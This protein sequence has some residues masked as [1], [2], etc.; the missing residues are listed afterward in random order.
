MRDDTSQAGGPLAPWLEVLVFACALTLL[1][2]D[3][4]LAAPTERV[5]L[6]LK[7]FHQFQ[8]AGYYAAQS[9][10]FY[11]DEDLNVEILEGAPEHTPTAMVLQGK[12]DFGVHDG[13]DLVYRRLQGD[14]LVAVAAIFQHSPVALLS[15]KSS[16]IRHPADLVS[17]EI[18]V[19]QSQGAVG[20]L[21][22]FRHEGV[23]VR[24]I[25]DVTPVHFVP[26]PGGEDS[27]IDRLA[28][29]RVAAVQVYLT[30]LP[31]P[32]PG[33]EFE[34]AILNPLDYGVDFYGDTLFTS[35][36]FLDAK[37]DVVARFR[38][39]SAKGWQ[40]AM[41]HREEIADLILTLPTGRPT[42]KNDR[43]TL[44][45]EAG[46]MNDMILPV[47]VEIGH[48]NPG[49]WQ[50]MADIYQ[51]LG[52]VTSTGRLEDFVY[53]VDTE[54]QRLR[55]QMQVLGIVIAAITL[56]SGLSL[57]WVRLL[58]SQVRVRTQE[59][60][61]RQGQHA[62]E[63]GTANARMAT[64]LDNIPDLA[65]VKDKEGRFVAVNRA[66]AVFM[67]FSAPSDMVGKTDLDIHS[68]DVAEA[69]R[70]EDAEVM[71]SGR[72][73]RV[74]QQVLKADG[75]CTWF[76]KIKTAL[77]DGNG[78]LAGTVGISRNI[79]ERRQNEAE[80]EAR[81]VAEAANQAK[82]EFLANMSHEIRTP[83]N[84]I[85]GMS[86]LAMQSGLNPQ[87][88]NYV[89]K[90]HRSA[91]SLLGIIN[92]ILDFSKIEAGHLDIEHIQFELGD[93]LDSL[94]TLLGMKAEEKG[95]ELVFD[96]PPDLPSALVGDP[97]RL[98][99]V[100]INLGNNAVKFTDRGEVVVGAEVL[101]RDA[102]SVRLRF[103]VRDTG[104]GMTPE[105]Q[106]RLFKPFSQAD[107]ST[108]RRFGGTG[109]GLAI[110][111][112]LV[113]MMGGE[114]GVDSAPGRGSRFDFTATF[115]IGLE[116]TA[117]DA[118]S[119][120]GGLRGARVLVVDD[121]DAA[122]EALMHMADSLGMRASAADDGRQAIE[123]VVAADARDEPFELLL[124]D[125]KM[126]G[127]NGVDCAKQLS[128]MPLAHPPPTV[129]MLTAFSRDEMA[130]ALAAERLTVAATLT[131]PVT[132]ST[133]MDASLQ[134]IGLPQAHGLRSDQREEEL[135][136]NRAVLAG[137]HVLLV[138]D[139][140]FNQE[141]ARELLGRAQIVVRVANN[142]REA[143]DIL[144]RER[145]DA[146]LMDCQMPVM[147]GYAAASELRSDPK[148]RDLPIIAMTANAM[149]GDRE[150]VLAAGMNDHIA[151]PINVVEMFATLAR[152]VRPEVTATN[153]PRPT[154]DSVRSLPSSE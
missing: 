26:M 110:S 130:R 84:A 82:S 67:G 40:Y 124:L 57:V 47:L 14:P 90:V 97:S 48:M 25:Y 72:G 85:L 73:I 27:F 132:P 43:K 46:V 111:H 80:R 127:M 109:L 101:A 136:G 11:R 104:I 147:D 34:P 59:L 114:L 107:S 131:K 145:F 98:R 8:F 125:W 143:I 38:R 52:M 23:A 148:W 29:G 152:W 115:G 108:S 17:R 137:A 86:H 118:A 81:R 117:D 63:L 36:G 39:A 116:R 60:V 30:R 135:Q 78:R 74:D 49:R 133:L 150:K 153:G 91:E 102:T 112:H 121:N 149:V 51:E 93:V 5:R 71:A 92:D 105:E 35:Q 53:A 42:K 9:K 1:F 69:N 24:S 129:L 37:P 58:R 44:L 10:G 139:N 141:L 61:E 144:S 31:S 89:Q 41:E 2:H 20:L 122:R 68:P 100:L 103:E 21:A 76:E 87:Q 6:Q 126:P 154:S 83:M 64:I 142:G 18:G 65:W 54:K 50:R 70:I 55:K 3:S 28:E 22:M 32:K 12:A 99:Q 75:T 128:R 19:D 4:A 113:R 123:A 77:Y 56:L 62:A 88:Y 140:P 16:N 146:V 138:E 120:D 13:A 33:N 15:K 151:K 7:W 106:L 45:E 66:L 94:A 134:A 96:L 119:T 95:L 79:T